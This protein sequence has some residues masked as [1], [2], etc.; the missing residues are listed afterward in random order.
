MA[1][2]VGI[3][4]ICTGNYI[5]F[6]EG[7]Y[8]SAEKY[9]LPGFERHY[10]VFTDGQINTFENQNIKVI[11]QEKLGW[12]LDTLFR[13]KMFLK[14]EDDLRTMDYLYFFNA[15]LVLLQT[16]GNEILPCENEE[17]TVVQH[18]GFF[19]KKR[20]EFTYDTNKK[21]L[22]Y[23]PKEEGTVYIAGGLNGGASVPYLKMINALSANIDDDYRRKVIALWHDES[24][25]NR[26]IIGKNVKILPPSYLYPEGWDIPFEKTILILD[27]K[28]FGGHKALRR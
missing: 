28:R 27:K 15:N 26:Y 10:F 11:Y 8:R 13:F 3:L 1:Q 5:I 4:Y 6:W 24:H 9:L 16:A 17:L 12:P 21:S 23:I 7:F 19:N 18:P 22:A 20:K 2:N 14:A 25:I